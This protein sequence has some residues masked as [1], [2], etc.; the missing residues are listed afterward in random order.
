MSTSFSRENTDTSGPS[1]IWDGPSHSRTA[2][3]GQTDQYSRSFYGRSGRHVLWTEG[4]KNHPDCYQQQ[5]QRQYIRA[6]Y[7]AFKTTS[8]PGMSTYFF[9]RD[10]AKQLSVDK[11]MAEDGEGMGTD[12]PAFLIRVLERS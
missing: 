7:A 2:Y 1:G 9:Q 6:T 3:C 5:V 4:T 10:H 12:L 11:N 8:F